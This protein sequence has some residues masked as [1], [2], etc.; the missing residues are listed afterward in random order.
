MVV[1]VHPDRTRSAL[2]RYAYWANPGR[3]A[4]PALVEADLRTA[5]LPVRTVNAGGSL[6]GPAVTSRLLGRIG[7]N[8]EEENPLTP[9]E[10]E[11]LALLARGLKNAAIAENLFISERTVKFHVGSILAKLGAGNRT[12][13]SATAR[14]WR[15]DGTCCVKMTSASGPA[16]HGT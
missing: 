8:P 12:E 9:R 5:G 6:L 10:T 13:D 7:E 16:P 14:A 2:D 4:Y 11:V 15:R 3:E 1:F